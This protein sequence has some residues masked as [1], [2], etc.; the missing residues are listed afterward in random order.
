VGRAR[1]GVGGVRVEGGSAVRAAMGGAAVRP[2]PASRP[3]GAA[4]LR[5]SPPAPAP[6]R[7]ARAERRARG[8]PPSPQPC[9]VTCGG[10]GT[11]GLGGRRPRSGRR[12]AC[13]TPV[14]RLP[15]PAPGSLPLCHT[16][17]P[18]GRLAP[19]PRARRASGHRAA[20]RRGHLPPA[21]GMRARRARRD[22]VAAGAAA[23]RPRPTSCPAPR[24]F[25]VRPRNTIVH[26]S[27]HKP[28]VAT[29]N[30]SLLTDPSR[31]PTPRGPACGPRRAQ[32]D[33]TA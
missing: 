25:A 8:P 22:R 1:A 19:S 9:C 3:R 29:A 31:P 27:A 17:T 2:R 15:R 12:L 33:P 16:P 5:R 20:G 11:Q 23:A 13:L 24:T 21:P 26:P 7:A 30:G 4:V 32:E 18:P 6:P 28:V 14:L 10:G